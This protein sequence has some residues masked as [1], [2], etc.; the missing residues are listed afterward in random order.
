MKFDEHYSKLNF[1]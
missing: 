1:I